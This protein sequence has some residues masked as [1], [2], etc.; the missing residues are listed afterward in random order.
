MPDQTTSSYKPTVF[1]SY[2]HVDETWKNRLRPHLGALEKAGRIAVWDDRKIDAGDTWYPEIKTAMEQAAVAV[3]LISADF[4]N[5]AFCV[6]EEVPYFLQRRER[7]GL[8]IIP[9]LLRPCAWRAIPWLEK[10]QMLPRDYKSVAVNFKSNWDTVFAEI[11][12][13][14]FEIIDNPSYKP[15]AP[16]APVW[17]MPSKIDIARL[18]ITGSDLFGRAKEAEA[19]FLEAEEMQ[20]KRQPDF[21]IHYSVRGFRYCDLLLDQG[22]HHMVKEHATRTVEIAKRNGQLLSI[23][24]DNLSLGRVCLVQKQQS[25]NDDLGRAAEFLQQAIDGLRQ[26]GIIEFMPLG[27]L[28]R[29]E[30]SRVTG[31]YQLAQADLNKAQRIAERSQMRLHLTDCLL[32]RARLCLA[33]GDHDSACEHWATA[34]AMVEQIGYHRRDRDLEEIARALA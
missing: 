3:C 18:P 26:A 4:L 13:R 14:V 28:A 19:A 33:M 2:S 20:K 9:V 29:A 32:E 1:I 24:L 12:E 25:G 27:L 23:A 15:P 21:P 16:P 30:L 17:A 11:A 7:D 22:K 5:S 31:K 10:M 6:K 8:V 34:E